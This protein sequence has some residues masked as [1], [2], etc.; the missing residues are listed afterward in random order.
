M[1]YELTEQGAG[2]IDEA[3]SMSHAKKIEKDEAKKRGVTITFKTAAA[4]TKA[5]QKELERCQYSEGP[6]GLQ[7]FTSPE[8]C[9]FT[10]A[11][12]TWDVWSAEKT[13]EPKQEKAPAEKVKYI[14]IL[15]DERHRTGAKVKRYI[16]YTEELGHCYAVANKKPPRYGLWVYSAKYGCLLFNGDVSRFE[17]L[18]EN[19]EKIEKNGYKII[20]QDEKSAKISYLVN[21]K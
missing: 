3:T 9:I 5:L 10:F 7:I 4:Y 15:D 21:N 12:G 11:A 14:Y 20:E 18:K 2:L 16:G 13:E 19:G 1:R 6:E 8:N 17:S